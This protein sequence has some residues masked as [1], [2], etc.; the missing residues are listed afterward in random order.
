MND[1]GEVDIL[2][3]ISMNK[4][5]LSQKNFTIMERKAAD[6]DNDGKV[7]PTDSLNVMKYIVQLIPDLPV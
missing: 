6:V 5:I 3:I 2:D 1:D 7:T 4:G